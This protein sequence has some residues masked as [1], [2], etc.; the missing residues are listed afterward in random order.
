MAVLSVVWLK[1]EKQLS[2][3]YT[4]NTIYPFLPADAISVDYASIAPTFPQTMLFYSKD[5]EPF[6]TEFHVNMKVT[7]RAARD[8]TYSSRP[9]IN[10]RVRSEVL[11]LDREDAFQILCN[12][13]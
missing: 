7:N 8:I 1:L 3:G 6:G 10:I 9:N 12:Y 11:V 13:S 2:L 4:T 5:D